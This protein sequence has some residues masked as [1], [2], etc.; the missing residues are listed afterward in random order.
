MHRTLDFRRVRVN[1]RVLG[2][3]T[4]ARH[5]I[6]R[7]RL[8][9]QLLY[10][11]IEVVFHLH[12][13]APSDLTA[14]SESGQEQP[15]SPATNLVI[16]RNSERNRSLSRATTRTFATREEIA[17]DV[18]SEGRYLKVDDIKIGKA[19]TRTKPRGR[20]PKKAAK[21]TGIT[22]IRRQTMAS[23][24]VA[25]PA[26]TNLASKTK[27]KTRS[28]PKTS[29]QLGDAFLQEVFG[30]SRPDPTKRPRPSYTESSSDGDEHQKVTKLFDNTRPVVAKRKGQP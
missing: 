9:L 17:N 20:P 10:A 16:E 3:S 29:T 22:N 2:S 15:G 28:R 4:A 18:P 5:G 25:L 8:I 1:K 19:S 6:R 12:D 11:K 30:D 7:A 26:K 13:Q 21:E 23:P 14:L 24:S 27:G